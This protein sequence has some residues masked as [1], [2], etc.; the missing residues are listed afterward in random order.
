M[1]ILAIQK[2][3]HYIARAI[4]FCLKTFLFPGLEC[5]H[6]KFWVS[7]TD[8]DPVFIN[9][10]LGSLAGLGSHSNLNS[11]I[12]FNWKRVWLPDIGIYQTQYR[13]QSN[14]GYATLGTSG[15]FHTR[16]ME[17]LC[18]LITS[19]MH[20]QHRCQKPLRKCHLIANEV[21]VNCLVYVLLPFVPNLNE[22]HEKYLKRDPDCTWVAK[23]SGSLKMFGWNFVL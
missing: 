16:W 1:E 13:N 2:F 5:S 22:K 10:E 23:A 17:L 6:G 9:S 4:L 11:S 12:V 14:D 15:F 20:Q 8:R 7:I 19:G 18:L 3:G 21:E